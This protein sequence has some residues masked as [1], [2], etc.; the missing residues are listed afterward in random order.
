M[1]EF[2]AW[3]F[4]V[5]G[6]ALWLMFKVRVNQISVI[7]GAEDVKLLKGSDFIYC[8]FWFVFVIGGVISSFWKR[9]SN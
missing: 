5:S 9:L 4:Y 2:M 8:L 7:S 3:L 1:A 6:C